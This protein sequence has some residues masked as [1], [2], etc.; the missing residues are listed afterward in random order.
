MANVT[1]SS[2][3]DILSCIAGITDDDTFK[4]IFNF[5]TDIECTKASMPYKD[6][7][8]SL[9]WTPRKSEIRSHVPECTH[10]KIEIKFTQNGAD[11]NAAGP[12]LILTSTSKFRGSFLTNNW[13]VIVRFVGRL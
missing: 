6:G 13:G 7:I 5:I 12:L 11:I 9:H 8:I 4:N 1:M 2:I 3:E 10:G